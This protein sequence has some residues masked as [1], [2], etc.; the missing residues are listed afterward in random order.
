MQA[1][2]VMNGTAEEVAALALAV[3]GRQVERI[4]YDFCVKRFIELLLLQLL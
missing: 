1:I 2:I 4:G 3:Q